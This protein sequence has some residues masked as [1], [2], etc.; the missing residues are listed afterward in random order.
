MVLTVCSCG[1]RF[2][3]EGSVLSFLFLYIVENFTEY[4]FVFLGFL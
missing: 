1:R 3:K 4:L 2:D